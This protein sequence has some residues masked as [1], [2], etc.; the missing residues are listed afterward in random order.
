MN[1]EKN[2]SLQHQL[3]FHHK[4]KKENGKVGFSGTNGLHIVVVAETELMLQHADEAI[5]AYIR[6]SASVTLASNNS[7]ICQP[8]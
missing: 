8:T 4:Q 3:K 5:L 1:N 6:K 2:C 7:S